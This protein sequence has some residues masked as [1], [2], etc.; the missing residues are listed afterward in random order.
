[1]R[2]K[3]APQMEELAIRF[4]NTVAWHLRVPSEERL[5]SRADVLAWLGQNGVASSQELRRLTRSWKARPRDATTF[6]EV[7][8]RLREIIY[9]L[10]VAQINGKPPSAESLAFFSEFLWQP[11]GLCL[12]W[13]NGRLTWRV[14]QNSAFERAPPLI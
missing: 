6:Y 5:G 9:A 3:L 7:A 14:R 8:M 4:V 13:K 2:S 12:R 1:M 10:F 11:S